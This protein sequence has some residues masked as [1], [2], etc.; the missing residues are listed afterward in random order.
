[1]NLIS[2]GRGRD[3]YYAKPIK[4]HK[5]SYEYHIEGCLNV[6]QTELD[7]NKEVLSKILE[8]AG[9]DIDDFERK[10]YIAIA[11]HDIG[12]LSSTFQNQMEKTIN[13]ESIKRT[14]YFRHELLSFVYMIYA[15]QDS[16]S[17]YM[18]EFPYH[19]Y[20][21]LSHHKKIDANFKAFDRERNRIK[22]W[23]KLTS[24]EYEYGINLVT[25]LNTEG[26]ALREHL[27][28]FPIKREAVLKF[29]D[30]FT[31]ESY[32]L[33]SELEREDTRMLYSLCK[34]LVQYCDWIA[35]ADKKPLQQKLNQNQL[36]DKIRG[37]V[38]TD[39]NQ[40][41]ERDFHKK[42]AMAMGD[43]IAIAPT[44]SGKTEAS[45]LWAVNFEKRNIIFLMPTMVTSNSIF[46]RLTKYYFE[47]EYCGLSHSNSDVYF[48]I[49]EEIGIDSS[50]LRFELL[51]YKAFIPPIMV[52]T[53]DQVLTSG[54]NLGYWALKEYSLVGSSIIFDEIQAYDTFTLGL[55][56]ETIKKIKK[57]GGNVM[58]MSAT[59]PKFLLEHF[60]N[61]LRVESPIIATE[62]MDRKQNKW[63]FI[64]KQLEDIIDVIEDYLDERD[65]RKKVAVVVNNIEKAKWLYDILS[66]KYKTL[67]LH[68]EFI[69]QDRINK[70]KI[71][72]E[73]NDYSLV[74]ATQVLE[75]SLDVSFN[76]IFS[77]CAPIDSLVQRAGRCNRRGEYNDSEFI[78]FDYSTISEKYV[79]KKSQ[80]I[81]LKS[82]EAVKENQGYL[83][84]YDI[85]KIID[86]VYADFNLYDENYN[87]AVHLYDRIA[88]E[89]VV[90]DLNYNEEKLQTRLID[91]TKI[92]IIP[93][94]FK[95]KVEDLFQKKEYAK[96]ALYEVPVSLGRYKKYILINYC[97]NN[98]NLPI[99]TVEYTHDKGIIYKDDGHEFL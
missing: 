96:I 98:Y 57:L 51:Q 47:R 78:V 23:P 62:L 55:I 95:D 79:Y 6:F 92:S 11:M 12:K 15:T 63:R 90:F 77:E 72:E 18:K 54:F 91:N 97:E 39:G 21:V 37:K 34:G 29:M 43:V 84:E 68:S 3:M 65:K 86:G 45:L 71:L 10:T 42:C 1:M 20:A 60:T 7:R 73:D 88:N 61:I 9:Q 44:G 4:G 41:I 99:Y 58:V 24:E 22:D 35:S 81:L 76:I 70:E 28:D 46:D 5:G 94:I 83:S 36:K 67:C 8:N 13:K 53:V 82:K 48:A 2:C 49:N 32:L 19:L 27:E 17:Q 89:E 74:I 80:D 52:S 93:Y 16:M 40:Y 30:Y 69:M 26:L 66:P 75:V 59:M 14:D 64:D 31:T 33:S 50:E 85:A 56:T 25:K 87:E 38:E